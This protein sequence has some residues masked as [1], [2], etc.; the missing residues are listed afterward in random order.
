MAPKKKQKAGQQN[1]DE[2]ISSAFDK[3]LINEYNKHGASSDTGLVDVLTFC[4]KWLGVDL[5]RSHYLRILLKMFYMNSI[6]NEHLV[7]TDDDLQHILQIDNFQ[8]EMYGYEGD[9][10]NGNEWLYDKA[11]K[12]RNGEITRPFQYMVLALGRRSGKAQTLNSKLLTP[13]G[14]KRMGDIQVGDKVMSADGKPTNVTAIYPQ[15]KKDIYRVTMS[16]G[17]FTDC[18]GEHLWFTH[19]KSD[20]KNGFGKRCPSTQHKYQGSVKSTLEIKQTLRINRPDGKKELNHSIPMVE[21]IQFSA[22]ETPLDPY[23]MGLLIGDGTMSAKFAAISTEDDF[24]IKEAARLIPEDVEIKQKTGNK[25][26]DYGLVR[27][28][29]NKPNGV[30]HALKNLGLMGSTSSTKFLPDCYKFNSVEARVAL[31]QGLMDTDGTVDKRQGK[32]SFCTVSKRLS[33]DVQFLV[34][35]LGGI[36]SINEKKRHYTYKGERKLGK[37]AYDLQ[38]KLPTNI[39]PF[40]L[41][42]KAD[43]YNLYLPKMRE[44]MRTIESI[45]LIGHEEAQC[46]SVDHSTHL[47]VTDHCIVT[48][49]TFTSSII[50][51]YEIYK[52]MEIVVCKNCNGDIKN[53]KDMEACPDCG[54]RCENHP[55]AYYHLLDSE[56][57]RILMCATTKAQAV[58]PGFNFVRQRVLNCPYFDGRVQLGAEKMHFL[59]KS[60]VRQNQRLIDTGQEPLPGSIVVRPISSNTSSAHGTGSVMILFDE[61]GLF[62]RRGQKDSDA[63]AMEALRPQTLSYRHRNDGRMLMISMPTTEDGE[64]FEHFD[65]GKDKSHRAYKN[66]LNLQMPTWEFSNGRYSREDCEELAITE[67]KEEGITFERM[68]GAQFSKDNEESFIPATTID[69]AFDELSC[70]TKLD[71]P[72]AR[73]ANHFMHIDCSMNTCNYAYV[74]VHR[75]KRKNVETG[76]YENVYVQDDS[77]FWKPNPQIP[78]TFLDGETGEFCTIHQVH[79]YIMKKAKAFK[80]ASVSYDNMQSLESKVYFRKYNLNLRQVSFGGPQQ[81]EMFG[82]LRTA[83][84]ENRVICCSNDW[85]LRTELKALRTKFTR[86]GFRVYSA[87]TSDLADCLAGAIHVASTMEVVHLPRASTVDTGGMQRYRGAG[88]PFGNGPSGVIKPKF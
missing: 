17:S 25:G 2:L 58:D 78:D 22:Q 38:I 69:R 49:N 62:P 72:A 30:I 9:E 24:I 7:L 19:T 84:L 37:L 64:F 47:Y 41:P 3:F 50:I 65:M 85:Q 52:L 21:P 16:D 27:T 4:D 79:E 13:S 86:N 61:F 68:Y 81:A 83:M 66:I 34:Q 18:C 43:I 5:T 6:G 33:E 48:H 44:P 77:K 82:L 46:I 67:S 60:D 39:Q 76:K 53:V 26:L 55:Q 36:C 29:P 20:R 35:S 1:P 32:I 8:R 70:N 71:K 45:E 57:L 10:P 54:G 42:R 31:L 12:L 73:G 59:T 74:I 14:W 75:E 40:K 87:I 23:L 56:P 15:G 88:G 51:C 11:C 63:A 80:C 28:N